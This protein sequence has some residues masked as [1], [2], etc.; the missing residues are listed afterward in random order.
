MIV[1]VGQT[2]GGVGKS[3]LAVNIATAL[4]HRGRGVFVID[5]DKQRTATTWGELR[6][7]N[8]ISPEVRVGPLQATQA[9]ASDF[10]EKVRALDGK[11]G[12]D[13]L[14]VDSG[15]FDSKELRASLVIADILLAPTAPNSA[16]I[17]A[18]EDFD[19]MV[20]DASMA[21]PELNAQVVINRAPSLN[22]YGFIEQAREAIENFEHLQYEGL[23]VAD[24]PR[25]PAGIQDGRGIMDEKNPNES[26]A[27]AQAEIGRIADLIENHHG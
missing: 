8:G 14:I 6:S 5:A 13:F 21:N 24:R 17:W 12:I 15:G 18:L 11:D 16:D 27:K 20:G 1:L 19:Q 2:K 25:I 3:T 10:I 26:A 9:N 22:F 4:A 23:F 7:V